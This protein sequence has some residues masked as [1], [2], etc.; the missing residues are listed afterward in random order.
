MTRTRKVVEKAKEVVEDN[1]EDPNTSRK[2]SGKSW[3]YDHFPKYKGN[4]KPRIGFYQG[5]VTPQQLGLGSINTYDVGDINCGIFVNRKNSY[6]F[7]DDGENEPAEDL[8][9]YLVNEVKNVIEDNQSEFDSIE[10]FEYIRP[11][12]IQNPV[13]PE[14]QNWI[15]Q[16]IVFETRLNNC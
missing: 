6:D 7:N 12:D 4:T 10:D 15:F 1:I 3:V 9:N 8:L 14:G 2:N 5:P 16:Q 11:T 13:R